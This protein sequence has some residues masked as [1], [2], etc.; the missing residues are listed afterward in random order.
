MTP[1]ML[2]A[3][4]NRSSVCALLIEAGADLELCDSS[5]RDALSIALAARATESAE[6]LSASSAQL[7]PV[8][9]ALQ[10]H[11]V[12]TNRVPLLLRLIV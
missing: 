1:L 4:K 2:A 6:I 12:D 5:G 9:E 7:K 8:D 3:S 11:E 10:P